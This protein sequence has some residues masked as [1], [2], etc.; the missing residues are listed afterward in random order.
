MSIECPKRH[1]LVNEQSAICTVEQGVVL[2]I[3][4]EIQKR[5]TEREV[6]IYNHKIP[7]NSYSDNMLVQFEHNLQCDDGIYFSVLTQRIFT[8]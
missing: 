4:K 6:E 8:G 7:K 5:G 3:I 1:G 2:E